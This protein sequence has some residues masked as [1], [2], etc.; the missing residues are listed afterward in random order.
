MAR[1]EPGWQTALYIVAS[2]IF[3]PALIVGAPFYLI[4]KILK[5]YYE[6]P[7][8][9]RQRTR[10]I[11]GN[12]HHQAQSIATNFPDSETF[13]V[14]VFRELGRGR[15]TY[16]VRS[17]LNAMGYACELLYDAEGLNPEDIASPPLPESL[18]GARYRDKLISYIERAQDP[19]LLDVARGCVVESFR[20]FAD[21]LPEA[22]LTDDLDA[23]TSAHF[24]IPFQDTLKRSGKSVE[25]LI[26]PFYAASAFDH[27]VFKGL[28]EQLDRNI[29]AVSGLPFSNANRE[30]SKLLKPGNYLGSDAVERYLHGTPLLEVFDAEVPFDIPLKTRFKH[31]WIVG[32]SGSG[33][34]T[35][36]ETQIAWDLERVARGECS[37]LII[38]SQNVL[39]PKIAGLKLFAPGAPLYG[40]LTLLEPDPDHVLALNL[41]DM[42][43]DDVDFHDT[44]ERQMF[45][46]SAAE[47]IQFSLSTMSEQQGEL[48]SYVIQLVMTIEGAT[49]DTFREILQPKGVEKYRDVLSSMDETVQAFFNGVFNEPS[50]RITKDAVLRRV[51][52]MLSNSTF[53]KMFQSKTNRFRMMHELDDARV[54][55]I[56]T[57]LA[58]FKRMDAKHSV[59][60]SSLS[61]FMPWKCGAKGCQCF[62]TS[63]K[64]A[65][66]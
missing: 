11:S 58:Y 40:K 2:I 53:R 6:S 42:G 64:C 14:S 29:C 54:I 65:T 5:A 43:M 60:S 51:L 55:L 26:L 47:L 41:F 66:I 9:I 44:R 46:N 12:L 20:A 33:K 34:T 7:H 28:R 48:F 38:D 27:G 39:I 61:S 30:S 52:G 32:P 21:T 15:K 22:S 49:I 3:L 59:G 37:L 45:E 17:I 8:K 56:N 35:L 10:S 31:Q 23:D 50:F 25:E 62:A 1:D 18:E 4:Y 57:D 16:P 36:I 13:A 63:M 24:S 19:E